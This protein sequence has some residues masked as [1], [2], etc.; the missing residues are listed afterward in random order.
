[1]TNPFAPPPAPACGRLPKF[2]ARLAERPRP[3][4][5]AWSFDG[6]LLPDLCFVLDFDRRHTVEFLRVK[7]WLE[8]RLGSPC[9]DR[10]VVSLVL[11]AALETLSEEP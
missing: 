1:M 11:R 7:N 3:S 6:L 8:E 2:L 5:P 4:E 10:F 9:S